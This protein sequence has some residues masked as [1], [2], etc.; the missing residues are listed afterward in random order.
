[1]SVFMSVSMSMSMSVAVAV[2][3]SV[4]VTVYQKQILG[5]VQKGRHM[6]LDLRHSSLCHVTNDSCCIRVCDSFIRDMTY[7][8]A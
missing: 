6:R 8:Y 2:A 3:V 1:M 7:S 5:C 4:A